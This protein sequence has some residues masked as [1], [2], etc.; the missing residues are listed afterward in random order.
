MDSH[1]RVIWK[2]LQHAHHDVGIGPDGRIYALT[3]VIAAGSIDGFPQLRAPRIEDYLAVLD[4][5]G[6]E[7]KRVNLLQAM[8]RSPYARLLTTVPWYTTQDTGDHLHTNSVDVL[9]GSRAQ[10]LAAATAGRV[11]LSFREINTIAILDVEH[12]A[13][14]WATHGPWLRQHDPD[15]LANGNILLFDNQGHVGSGGVTRLVEFDPATRRIA[16]T[17]AGTAEQPFESEVRSSQERLP[18]GNTL[19]TESDGGRLFEVT[20]G[21]DVVWNCVNPVRGGT[22]GELVPIVARAQ[23]VDPASPAPA[24]LP[25]ARGST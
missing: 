2:Y 10:K 24:F 1:S 23:R 12:E 14:V 19:I 18:N 8:L 3:N 25:S 16:W 21:G 22:S 5:D 6:R 17:Y 4:A 9:D 20:P 7:L 13:I 15:L 11:L